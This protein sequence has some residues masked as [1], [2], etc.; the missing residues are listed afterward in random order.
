MVCY[1]RQEHRNDVSAWMKGV[2]PE[3]KKGR[4]CHHDN[5][6]GDWSGTRW[7]T[8][9]TA[10]REYDFEDPIRIRGGAG[11][12]GGGFVKVQVIDGQAEAKM[13]KNGRRVMEELNGGTTHLIHI[14]TSQRQCLH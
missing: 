2:C 6:W 10:N 7:D 3:G 9:A 13:Q 4:L 12:V 8:R 14:L 1:R 11:A 5:S